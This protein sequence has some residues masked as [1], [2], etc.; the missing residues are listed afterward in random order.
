M[1]NKTKA[2]IF[3]TFS[4]LLL[5]GCFGIAFIYLL[6]YGQRKAEDLEFARLRGEYLLDESAILKTN[7][8]SISISLD[9]GRAPVSSYSFIS[10]LK[11]GFYNNSVFSNIATDYYVEGGRK[12][13]R[14][15]TS[16]VSRHLGDTYVE[17]ITD[18]VPTRGDVLLVNTGPYRK[19]YHFLI[20]TTDNLSSLEA[21]KGK[22]PVVGKVV[23]GMNIIEQVEKLRKEREDVVLEQS[24]VI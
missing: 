22:F 3:R 11:S 16:A 10:L 13:K 24:R 5:I 15:D 12:I 20:V 9:P 7:I 2:D 17:A 19:D 21:M 1:N 18:T 8:G 23:S 14:G 4:Y 6:I